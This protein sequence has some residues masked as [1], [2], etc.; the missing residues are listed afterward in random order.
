MP[1]LP[2][3]ETTCQALKPVC[4]G[5]VLRQLHIHR[6]DLRWEISPELPSV[7][8]G[9]QC[10]SVSRRSKYVLFSFSNGCIIAHLGMSGSFRIGKQHDELRKHEH[11]EMVFGDISVRLHDPRRFGCFLWTADQ[12]KHPLLLNIG[13]EPLSENF[14]ANDL[15]QR[16][17]KR[18]GPIKTCIMDAKIVCGVGNI[19]ANEALFNAGIHP[20]TPGNQLPLSFIEKLVVEIKLIL[21]KAIKAGGCSLKDFE[22]ADRKLGYF[23]MDLLVYGRQ[24]LACYHCGEQLKEIRLSNRSTVY[25]S[26]CQK[27]EI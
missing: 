15:F 9:E 8:V 20:L 25:C 22:S 5:R 2:E 7:V 11:V 12:S 3:V 4:E 24:N 18:S 23:Q 10:L 19:Y 27:V 1:E 16:L 21:K 6:R 13:P 17:K 26:R 14:N